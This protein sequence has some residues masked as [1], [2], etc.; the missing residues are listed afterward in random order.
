MVISAGIPELLILLP[1]HLSDGVGG[2]EIERRTCNIGNLACRD[3]ERV[4]RNEVAGPDGHDI[5]LDRTV[6]LA[7][8]AEERMVGNIDMGLLVGGGE[9][10]NAELA[11]GSDG[12]GHRDVLVAGIS[13]HSVRMEVVEDN[14]GVR[15]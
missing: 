12:I 4:N 11:A 3:A 8:E 14:A 5:V 7:S 10:V 13:F 9:I 2:P 1:D 6:G 15:D